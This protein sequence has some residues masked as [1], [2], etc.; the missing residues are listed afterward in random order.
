MRRRGSKLGLVGEMIDE[1]VYSLPPLGP[2]ARVADLCGGSGRAALAV[3]QAYPEAHAVPPRAARHRPPPH[4][5]SLLL[6]ALVLLLALALALGRRKILTSSSRAILLWLHPR[7]T[8]K[9]ARNSPSCRR[10][11]GNMYTACWTQARRSMQ[12]T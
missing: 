5:H 2:A 8:L 1:L 11:V 6:L 12:P 4:V 3:L 7:Q 9:P 10:R